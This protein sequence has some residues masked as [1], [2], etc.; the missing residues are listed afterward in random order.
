MSKKCHRLLPTL[1][2][3]SIIVSSLSNVVYSAD[4]TPNL[5]PDLAPNIDP[6]IARKIDPDKLTELASSKT[7]HRLT[8]IERKGKD[9]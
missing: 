7:W 2:W 5:D 6:N 8:K 9:R 3:A 4:L 1:L